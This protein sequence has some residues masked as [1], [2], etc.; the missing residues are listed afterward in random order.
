VIAQKGGKVAKAAR[1]QLEKTTGEEVV[2]PLNAK[3]IDHPV[4]DNRNNQ[5]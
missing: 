3:N 4:L 1:I 2:T 5:E